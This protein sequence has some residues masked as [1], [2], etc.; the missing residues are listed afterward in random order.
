MEVSVHQF[1]VFVVERLAEL[2]ICS[3]LPPPHTKARVPPLAAMEGLSRMCAELSGSRKGLLSVASHS[4][5]ALVLIECLRWSL[6]VEASAGAALALADATGHLAGS[7]HGNRV[8]VG[9]LSLDVREV[10][11]KVVARL[12][13]KLG[14][15]AFDTA[16]QKMLRA[17]LASPCC[18][19]YFPYPPGSRQVGWH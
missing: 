10:A 16:S 19:H 17:A 5:C 18:W 9:L 6:P 8:V 15:L 4:V 3:L 11:E 7:R 1:G 12:K 14:D 13:P 2:Q